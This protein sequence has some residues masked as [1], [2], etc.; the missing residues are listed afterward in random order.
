MKYLKTFN[1]SL[2][3]DIQ[4]RIHQ[5]LDKV[6]SN[7]KRVN[8]NTSDSKFCYECG[9]KLDKNDI[10]C[11]ECGMD[12]NPSPSQ[13]TIDGNLSLI[14]TGYNGSYA[15]T[16]SLV[17]S[18]PNKTLDGTRIELKDDWMELSKKLGIKP[19]YQDKERSNGVNVSVTGTTK[20]GKAP[21]F[22]NPIIVDRLE[23]IKK[24]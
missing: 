12:Q 18:S 11:G 2:H 24:V 19:Y 6:N 3:D 9:T 10:F 17:F 4:A 5:R 20:N 1:E 8:S 13:F 22:Q 16:P 15:K 23:D 21:T 14:Y 7:L